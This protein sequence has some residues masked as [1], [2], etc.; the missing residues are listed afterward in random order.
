MA[1]LLR[2]YATL[3]EEGPEFDSQHSY[4]TPPNPPIT[5]TPEGPWWQLHLSAHHT[6]D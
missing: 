6:H 1:H 5:L 3:A 2:A 4:W